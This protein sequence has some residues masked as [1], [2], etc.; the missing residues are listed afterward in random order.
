MRE[1][2]VAEVRP[3]GVGGQVGH[4][5]DRTGLERVQAGAG[6]GAVLGL[7]DLLG[8]FVAAGY[9]QRLPVAADGDPAR[10]GGLRDA[11]GK[12]RYLSEEV[13]DA[14]GGQQQRLQGAESMNQ[15]RCG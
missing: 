3:P 6:A 13:V 4:V 12:L 15:I 10:G 11:G 14:L 7:V 5:D 1:R 8:P 2:V 9:R